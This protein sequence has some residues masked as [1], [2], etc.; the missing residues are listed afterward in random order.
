MLTDEQQRKIEIILADYRQ[1]VE[2]IVRDC[3]KD[4]H[5]MLEDLDTKKMEEIRKA[6]GGGK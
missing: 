5:Q 6:M 4:V 3:K 1:K 2:T